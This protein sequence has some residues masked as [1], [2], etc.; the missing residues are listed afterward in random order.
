MDRR[1]ASFV[2]LLHPN[3][4]R[5]RTLYI[6]RVV[7]YALAAAVLGGIP[8]A[9]WA[10]FELGQEWR[11]TE[12]GRLQQ[13]ASSLKTANRSLRR[14]V[15]SL[16]DRVGQMESAR[17]MRSG[18]VRQLRQ[19]MGQLQNRIN[20][21][22]DEVGFYRNILD[23][24]KAS[25]D[26][27]VKDLRIHRVEGDGKD[28][29]FSFKLAQGVA[30]KDPVR[31]YARVAVVYLNEKGEEQVRFFPEGSEVRKRGMKAEFR[32]FQHFRG[33]IELPSSARPIRATVQLYDQNSLGELLSQ[34]HG[35]ESLVQA[36][37]KEAGDAE[38]E[39]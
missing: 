29:A 23:P 13:E 19:Q 36:Q 35:W 5:P 11:K 27:S 8:G 12:V 10:A 17:A 6:R 38:Q 21:L 24:E 1:Y 16:R 14:Q 26:A 22:Q 34:A 37:R 33:R 2:F 32:Y 30:K 39:T 15:T 3:R 28:Y 7:F 25:R 20:K 4:G 31:G 9:I 18:E